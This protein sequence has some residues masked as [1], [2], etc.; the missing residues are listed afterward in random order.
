MPLFKKKEDDGLLTPNLVSSRKPDDTQGTGKLGKWK[1]M[2]KTGNKSHL[3][4]LVPSLS[5]LQIQERVQHKGKRVSTIADSD[6]GESSS[7][8]DSDAETYSE[9]DTLLKSI[10]DEEEE[11]ET[12]E[13]SELD[14][15][16]LHYIKERSKPSAYLQ[17]QL[18]NIISY[19]GLSTSTSNL[20]EIANEEL[21][22]TYSLLDNNVKI[23]RLSSS[24][25]KNDPRLFESVIGQEQVILIEKLKAKFLTLVNAQNDLGKQKEYVVGSKT[26][27]DR[28]GAVR[29]VIGRGAYGLIKV[30]DPHPD[31]KSPPYYGNEIYA[32]K[33]LMKRQGDAKK[34]GPKAFI[35]RVLSEFIISSTLNNKHIV[36]S[37]DLMISLG[38]PTNNYK[39]SQVM[40]CSS[41]SDLFSYAN[42]ANDKSG[43]RI[44][45]IPQEDLDCFVKQIAKGL[46]YMHNHG[47]AHCDLKL[48]NILISYLPPEQDL[49][50]TKIVLKISDFGKSNVFRTSWDEKEEL[51]PYA[52]GPIGSAPYIAPEEYRGSLSQYKNMGYSLQAK[53]CWALGI[54]ALIL[55]NI[56]HH[57]YGIK[58]HNDASRTENP[59]EEDDDG[60]VLDS[61]SSGYLWKTTE[62]KSIGKDKVV[63]Y[64]DKVFDEYVRTRTNSDYDPHTKE[65]TIKREG[66]F[67]P[68]EEI[69][70]TLPHDKL[71]RKSHTYKN[72]EHLHGHS[73]E[74]SNEDEL[75]ELRK[76]FI[77]KL[78]DTVP[79]K[80]L[81]V[82]QF[83][84]GDWM[85]GVDSCT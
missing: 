73:D 24:T 84:K 23:H 45:Y 51:F 42:N 53:D 17:S 2:F 26:L 38:C 25:K 61:Y 44:S 46:K 67:K 69:F 14:Y 28:Y 62:F 39:L 9:S 3:D 20:H 63:K 13:D 59:N 77:Y 21:K 72:T 64:K 8:S 47:V 1:A 82:D 18:S 81:S 19:C 76:L 29:D 35:E 75:N 12:G 68:I 34:E 37:V 27:F 11:E 10:S 36:K 54:I 15:S 80:R 83:L 32:V 41:G 16:H 4:N 74:I 49:T 48:E 66:T 22:K 71:L 78:L 85:I 52:A 30:V 60:R 79:T 31:K 57:K 5:S 33:E 55:F 70:L 6:S 58:T 56:R 50:R 7:E 43:H 65:W 40:E